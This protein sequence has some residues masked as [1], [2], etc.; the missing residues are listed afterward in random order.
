[1]PQ[2]SKG[3]HQVAWPRKSAASEAGRDTTAQ[4]GDPPA[5][6]PE[7]MRKLHK[8]VQSAS[9][10]S[11]SKLSGMMQQPLRLPPQLAIIS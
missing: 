2:S 3:I 6:N 8:S 1:M 5:H 9:R 10:S 4:V 11:G 7:T